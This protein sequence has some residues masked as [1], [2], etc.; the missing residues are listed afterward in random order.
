VPLDQAAGE[1]EVG[2]RSGAF[3]LDLSQGLRVG[4]GGGPHQVTGFWW[5]EM[6]RDE[7]REKGREVKKVG[8]KKKM[9]WK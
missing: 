9:R 8:V 4:Q 5:K 3:G 7:E 6:E 2:G 1:G